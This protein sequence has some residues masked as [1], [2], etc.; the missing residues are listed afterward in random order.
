MGVAL[1]VVG[2]PTRRGAAE[3]APTSTPEYRVKAAFTYHFI[4]FISGWHFDRKAEPAQEDESSR[5]APIWIGIVGR[6]PFKEAFVPLMERRTQ[7]RNIRIKRFQGLS[8]LDREDEPL[9]RHPQHEAI[10]KCDVVFISASEEDYLDTLLR[11]LLNEPVLTLADSPGFLERGGIVNFVTVERKVKFDINMAGA[12]RAR[13][14]LRS[15][16]LRLARRVIDED[17]LSEE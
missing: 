14:T 10:K 5:A 16:L 7:G 12:R 9:K 15:Q 2:G 13:L 11:P 17:D 8:Q 1:L 3:T 4:T 6:D